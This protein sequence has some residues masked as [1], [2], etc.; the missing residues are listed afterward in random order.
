MPTFIEKDVGWLQVSVDD[1]FGPEVAENLYQLGNIK[2]ALF[3][4]EDLYK[5]YKDYY[6]V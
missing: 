2:F 6:T 1:V 4:T 3:E 5:D